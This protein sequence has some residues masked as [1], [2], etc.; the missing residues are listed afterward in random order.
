MYD[1]LG[2]IEA[3]DL[4]IFLHP[5]YG[6]LPSFRTIKML[7]LTCHSIGIGNEHFHNSGHALFLALGIILPANLDMSI[8]VIYIICRLSYGNYGSRVPAYCQRNS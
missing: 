2:E 5:H 7:E 4:M 1:I 6:E 3:N 8:W